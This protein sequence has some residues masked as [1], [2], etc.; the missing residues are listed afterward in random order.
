MKL[1]ENFYVHRCMC[2]WSRHG[3]LSRC[4]QWH[5]SR[6]KR[7]GW[8]PGK[9]CDLPYL[10]QPQTTAKQTPNRHALPCVQIGRPRA[11]IVLAPR[12]I[13]PVASWHIALTDLGSAHHR[14]AV[15][16]HAEPVR[17]PLP[18]RSGVMSFV[19]GLSESECRRP[20]LL[21]WSCHPCPGCCVYFA[22]A[23][24]DDDH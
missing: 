23:D 3:T 2:T 1:L 6:R 8:K 22:T 16:E 10:I 21:V 19:A 14:L 9:D 12:S 5:W 20:L 24:D 17:S 4:W 18:H 11:A 13:S 15:L 7:C